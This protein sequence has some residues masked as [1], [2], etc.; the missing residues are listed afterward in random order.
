VTLGAATDVLWTYS[1]PDLYDLLVVRRHWSV[2][3]YG[4]FVADAMIAALLP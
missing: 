1:S 4:R 3:R 2:Q